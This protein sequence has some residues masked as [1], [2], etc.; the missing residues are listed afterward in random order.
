MACSGSSHAM[1]VT[2]SPLPDRAAWRAYVRAQ[3]E[4]GVPSLY[5]ASHVDLTGEPLEPEDYQLI[6]E[7]WQCYKSNRGILPE[8]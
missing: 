8:R 7:A 2:K 4:L 5:F 1:S 3:P 6:K